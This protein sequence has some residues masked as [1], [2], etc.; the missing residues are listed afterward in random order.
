VYSISTYI[1][2]QGSQSSVRDTD[3]S[4]A[5]KEKILTLEEENNM[6]KYKIELLLDMVI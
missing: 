1:I 3:L 4:S 5:A 2:E 6:L